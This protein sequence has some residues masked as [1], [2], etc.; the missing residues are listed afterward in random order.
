MQNITVTFQSGDGIETTE[1]FVPPTPRSDFPSCGVFAFAKSGSVLVNA[2]VREL[3]AEVGV[4]VIDWPEAG[5]ARG[6]DTASVQCDL[7]Q[8]FRRM[9]IAL[10]AFGKSRDRSSVQLRSVACAR[11]WSCVT[12]ATCWFHVIFP[13]GFRMDSRQEG[14]HGLRS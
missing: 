7:T 12:R 10:G 13:P 3:M 8:S 9:A 6:I 14:R 11:L 1:V 4:P 5:Y 2:I